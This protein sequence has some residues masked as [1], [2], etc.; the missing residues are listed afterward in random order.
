MGTATRRPH[1]EPGGPSPLPAVKLDHP[2]RSLL[3]STRADQRLVTTDGPAGPGALRTQR[4]PARTGSTWAVDHAAGSV[5]NE[6][7]VI[8]GIPGRG[9]DAATFEHA[10]LAEAPGLEA[11]RPRGDTAGRTTGTGRPDS[12]KTVGAASDV[13]IARALVGGSADATV[14]VRRP[15]WRHARGHAISISLAPMLTID[16]ASYGFSCAMTCSEVT[17]MLCFALAC[18]WTTGTKSSSVPRA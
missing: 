1:R 14:T 6:G 4:G 17:S 16:Q 12:L 3:V 2:V 7:G 8:V 9:Q 15:R 10:P 11:A 5:G 13:Q 18:A